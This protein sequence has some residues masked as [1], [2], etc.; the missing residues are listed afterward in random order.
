MDTQKRVVSKRRSQQ[1]KWDEKFDLLVKWVSEHDGQNPNRSDDVEENT[2]A[3]WRM[4]QRVAQPVS[5]SA[6][7]TH[8]DRLS[9]LDAEIPGWRGEKRREYRSWETASTEFVQWVS[10]HGRL[11]SF[12]GTDA[13]ETRHYFWIVNIR[14]ASRGN[15]THVYTEEYG[16]F[17]D[18]KTPGWRR[19]DRSGYS[20][21]NGT[22]ER[23]ARKIAEWVNENG[24]LP[25]RGVSRY[26]EEHK[27]GVWLIN[28]RKGYQGKAGKWSDERTALMDELIP[29]WKGKRYTTA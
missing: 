23:N 15:G 22:W 21:D 7:K 25:R 24:R 12:R 1:S 9:K 3:V 28:A 6:Q 5:A 16:E 18:E 26:P 17:L 8:A 19:T 14:N 20:Y 10:D 11:P 27:M 29:G 2:L 13:E 4:N